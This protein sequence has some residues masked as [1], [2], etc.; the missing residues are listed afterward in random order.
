MTD[1]VRVTAT[2]GSRLEFVNEIQGSGGMKD[3][4][5]SPDRSYVVAW[6]RERQPDV[7]KDRLM[8]IAGSYRERIFTQEGGDYWRNIFC[9]P[10]RVVEHDGRLGVASPF[11]QSRFFFQYGSRNG[12]FARIKGK[13]KQGKW[14]ASAMHHNRT[15]DP[16]ERGTWRDYLEICLRLSQAV[17]RLHAAGLAHSDLSYKNVLLDPPSGEVCLIDLDSL[18]VPG[19]FPP[20]VVGTPDFIAPE[21]LATHRL[22]MTDPRRK[23]PSIMT[24]RHALAVLIYLYLL[25]RH[26]LRGGKV[27]SLDPQRDEFLS[28]G[29]RALFIE[30]PT[31]V[32][33]RPNLAAVAPW[34]LPWSDVGKTPYAVCGKGIKALFDRAFVEGLHGPE[35][36]PTADEWKIGLLAALDLTQRCENPNCDQKW[37]V[38]DDSFR[39]ICPFCGTPLSGARPSLHLYSAQNGT[40]VPENRRL[41]TYDGRCLY[42]WH[43]NRRVIFDEKLTED[44]KKPVGRIACEQG[45]W[46]FVNERLPR[47]KDVTSGRDRSVPPGGAAELASGVHLLLDETEGGRLAL[48]QMA[49]M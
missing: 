49:R 36:R 10:T 37:F 33:N 32:S 48:V 22:P 9:W 20:D 14:F 40:F 43:V 41:A 12:D 4:Y 1:I 29:E 13:E 27:H 31:D 47:L 15:L 18:V 16:R 7:A 21:A 35:R 2:D 25:Y 28:M 26:P 17:H 39:A 5:F 23:L 30:H 45:R 42:A 38:E 44:E 19:K 24:D 3:V 46:L 34:S 8:T 11:F 6:Y